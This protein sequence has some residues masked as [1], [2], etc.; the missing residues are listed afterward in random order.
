MIH[1]CIRVY[2]EEDLLVLGF[3]ND[4]NMQRLMNLFI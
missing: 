1:T 3:L 4:L 2:L